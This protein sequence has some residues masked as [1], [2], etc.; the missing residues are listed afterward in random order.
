MLRNLQS[1]QERI[2]R[3]AGW[4]TNA[5]RG[6]NN[7]NA[8]CG[9]QHHGCWSSFWVAPPHLRSDARAWH[10]GQNDNKP[11]RSGRGGRFFCQI[12]FRQT[13]SRREGGNAP[14]PRSRRGKYTEGANQQQPPQ[15][16]LNYCTRL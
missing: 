16:T 3:G 4:K 5:L 1:Q 15:T 2:Q 14:L 8:C 10:V 11:S 9:L 6:G 7:G 12:L 13:E